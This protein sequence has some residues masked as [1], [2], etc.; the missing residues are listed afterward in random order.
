M[1]KKVV[2]N[3]LD[4]LGVGYPSLDY[5]VK[6]ND[7]P[8]VGMT[9][10]ILSDES[11]VPY[12]GGCV[13][14]I[15]YLMSAFHNKCGLSLSV[16]RDFESSGYKKYLEDINIDLSHV[17]TH[18]NYSTPFTK[19]LMSPSGEHTTL[20]YPGPM[21]ESEF[22][23]KDYDTNFSYGLLAIG[24]IQEN[25]AFLNHCIK[26]DIKTIFS[27]KGDYHSLREDYL[28]S[29]IKHSKIVFMNEVELEQLNDYLPQAVFQYL[30][31]DS[32]KIVVVTLGSKG[33]LVFS[34]EADYYVPSYS[35]T[36]VVDT[37]GGGDAFIAGFMS[38]YLKSEDLENSAIS[39]TA[40]A[41][42]IIEDFGCLTNIPTEDQLKERIFKIKENINHEESN[43]ILRAY[44]R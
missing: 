4:V 20:F 34:K 25:Q 17:S 13:V 27:M 43:I 42:F 26:H 24:E 29:A 30:E 6:L 44:G 19:M 41:S 10:L 16:G 8:K 33:S 35:G 32:E 40:L 28:I 1:I 11:E 38:E 39:G 21:I 31:E 15:V 9:S 37:S 3:K 22:K 36:K 7:D 18:S 14:N 23:E 2:M 5:I 12:Y